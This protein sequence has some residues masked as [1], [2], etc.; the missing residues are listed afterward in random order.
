MEGLFIVYKYSKKKSKRLVP[1]NSHF[2]FHDRI[3]NPIADDA[4]S[5]EPIPYA[6][7]REG[8]EGRKNALAMP[9]S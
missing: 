3:R 9:F 4:I 7:L 6:S 5:F 2:F 1:C 8:K